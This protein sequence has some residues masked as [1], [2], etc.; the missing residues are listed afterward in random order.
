MPRFTQFG[1]AR[2]ITGLLVLFLAV[3]VAFAQ[4]RPT[5]ATKAVQELMEGRYGP[6]MMPGQMPTAI[7]PTVS[8]Y[9]EGTPTDMQGWINYRREQLRYGRSTAPA[10]G[11]SGRAFGVNERET[12]NSGRNDTPRSGEMIPRFS[13]GQRQEAFIF[14]NSFTVPG[15][16]LPDRV[17][18][19]ENGSIPTAEQTNLQVGESVNYVGTIG[20]GLYG[21]SGT[22]SGD[23]DF[24]E[25]FLNAGER[26]SA[27][28]LT[29]FP[30]DDLDPIVVVYDQF[31]NILAAND[32][33]LLPN[34]PFSFDSFISF[35]APFTG[36]Y[37]LLVSGF[38]FSIF[39]TPANPFD[40]SSGFGAVSEGDYEVLIARLPPADPDYYTVTLNRGDILGAYLANV[41]GGAVSIE[42]LDGEVVAAT[43]SFASS[44]Y[45]A[46]SDL[47][48]F[49]DEGVNGAFVVAEPGRYSV[50]VLDNDGDY[51]LR[52]LRTQP[53]L[54]F[55]PRQKQTIFLDFNGG[56]F[57][58]GR[59]FG[60]PG[61][62]I[63]DLEP[64]AD[65]LPFWGIDPSRADFLIERIRRVVE[66]NL[67][68]DLE[69]SGLNA[70]FDVEVVA[71]T[72]APGDDAEFFPQPNTSNVFIGG[73]IA[74][75]GINT[76][77]VANS[78][79]VGNY[80]TEEVSIVLLDILSGQLPSS[81]NLNNVPLAGGKTIEDLVVT[82][83]GNVAAHEAGHYLGNWHTDGF[84]PIQNIMDEGPGG[85]FNLIGVDP[86]T[87]VFGD[88]GTIDVDFV[89]D[90][91]SFG[92]LFSGTE[93]TTAATAHAL[94]FYPFGGRVNPATPVTV[95][96]EHSHEVGHSML[97]QNFPNP[98]FAN[99]M[100]RIGFRVPE[101]GQVTLNLF[102]ISGRQVA[103]LFSGSVEQ[104]RTYI[105][106]LDGA[107][108]N[109][110][111]GTY[112]YRLETEDGMEQRT[113]ILN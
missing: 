52:L 18:D 39:S 78:I 66:E 55:Q 29:P 23:F 104:N 56:L 92:E 73:T 85:L 108:L 37:Y 6:K 34:E 80:D 90:T 9:P 93:N 96:T 1:I 45:P 77:G 28:L 97:A 27:N 3:N 44:G 83:V 5:K 58:V 11:R 69:R 74:S 106:D 50:G 107:A 32:D 46:S 10:Q 67:K 59:I 43:S 87:G 72:S 91:Y 62:D 30:L 49:F 60:S 95:Q 82:A 63:R 25:I 13:S 42:R 12:G 112:L 33:G 81:F 100:T 35:T 15:T 36:N 26:F 65:F 21:S 2:M 16:Q 47:G 61:V 94:T 105:V 84:S 51:V 88:R 14:G 48:A 111:Q 86:A 24:F 17:A 40:E 89:T 4:N 79:D 64:F 41:S 113:L 101:A 68:S 70:Y 53:G 57:D 19:E 109:L 102:D 31:G 20:D 71:N 103:N 54:E 110:A 7:D 99:G 75:S 98:A 8:F 22:G 76:I 38:P